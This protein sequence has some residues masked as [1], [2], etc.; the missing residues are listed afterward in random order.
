MLQHIKI[1]TR[2]LGILGILA[3]GYLFLLV[4]VQISATATHHRMTDISSALFPAALRIQ[5]AQ[6]AFERMKKHYSDAVVLQD[7]ESLAAAETDA[8]STDV[9]LREVTALLTTMPSLQKPAEDL[10]NRFASIR[11]RDRSLY[12]TVVAGK[13]T[14][15]DGMMSQLS[16]LG[17]ENQALSKSMT[18]LSKAIAVNFQNVLTSVD[19]WSIRSRVVGLVM[20]AV[21]ILSCICAGWVVQVKVVQPLQKLAARVRDIAE[22]EGDLTRRMHINGSD[23]IDEV[24]VWLNLF[25]DKLQSLI[26]QIMMNSKKL[27]HASEEL[28]TATSRMAKGSDEQQGQTAMVAAA[29]H[30]MAST[31]LEISRNSS[32]AA[33]K[34]RQASKAA[35][36]GGQV[37]QKTV[38]SMIEV[39]EAAERTALRIAELGQRSDGIGEIILVIDEIAGRTNLLALNAAIEAARAGEQGRGFAVVAGEVRNLAERTT[40]A[41]KEIAEMIS[42]LQHETSEARRVMSE[43]TLQLQ[44]VMG[45]AS[46]AGEKLRLIIES[47]EDAAGMV[48]QI[49]TAA[50]EQSAATDEINT[51]VSQIASI[52]Q[53]TSSNARRSEQACTALGELAIN[54]DAL[55]SKFKVAENP[56]PGQPVRQPASP[57]PSNRMSLSKTPHITTIPNRQHRRA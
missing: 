15:A 8:E 11:L 33:Q 53:E 28:K 52:S 5:E 48:N 22:G 7:S 27:N 34:T 20:L 43:G 18:D 35:G 19:E 6:A 29:M 55:V 3:A 1:K 57:L 42:G 13:G 54:L 2:I 56:E 47:S 37:V 9:A 31:V 24:G 32:M 44:Q 30:E 25:L 49:A 51:S 14:S 46:D 45:A 12:A 40:T 50:T 39:N 23:E 4:I 41:T 16:S 10:V 36:E 26:Q 38:A 21:A 17:K